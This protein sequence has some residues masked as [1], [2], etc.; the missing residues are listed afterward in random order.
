MKY[1]EFGSVVQLIVQLSGISRAQR[2][3]KSPHLPTNTHIDPV[4][5]S[6]FYRPVYAEIRGAA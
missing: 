3:A 5:L 1:A 6:R 4:S 2:I